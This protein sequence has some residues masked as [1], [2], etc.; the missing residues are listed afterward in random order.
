MEKGGR[1]GECR[2]VIKMRAEEKA[3]VRNK[4]EKKNTQRFSTVWEAH[5][6]TS[7][8]D[9]GSPAVCCVFAGDKR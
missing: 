1:G 7:V 5:A 8:C 9:F 4:G 6:G 3:H 2:A